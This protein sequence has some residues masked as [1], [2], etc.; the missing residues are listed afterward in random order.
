MV[1]AIRERPVPFDPDAVVQEFAALLKS[2]RIAAVSG[3]RY[4]GEWPRERFRKY[5]I[6]YRVADHTK[7][8]LYQALL[9]RLNAGTIE[10]LDHARC[11]KQLCALER[12]TARGG[13]ESIDHPPHGKDDVCNA[14]AGVAQAAKVAQAFVGRWRCERLMG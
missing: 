12:K 13:R 1:D 9:P 3:D 2:Y 11:V 6:E 7:S 4:A 5:G 8:E 14:V 10:L